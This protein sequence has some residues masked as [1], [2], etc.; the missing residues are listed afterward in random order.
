MDTRLPAE[1]RERVDKCFDGEGG[2]KVFFDLVTTLIW[3]NKAAAKCLETADTRH[4]IPEKELNDSQLTLETV[5]LLGL[6][7]PNGGLLQF[8]WNH[9]MWAERAPT[10]LRSIALPS[11]AEC[12]ERCTA[13]LFVRFGTYS[14]YRKRDSLKAYSE[15][16]AEFSFDEFDNAFY[17][18]EEEV[19]A[20]TIE[21]VLH[22]L[23][24]FVAQDPGLA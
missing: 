18:Q 5:A 7:I 13:E 23:D 17:D 15:C 8:F 11:L 9:P 24:D 14:E 4:V 19:Y 6:E 2:I 12:F 3:K 20:K 22:H 16:A 21:F 1:Q 10:S